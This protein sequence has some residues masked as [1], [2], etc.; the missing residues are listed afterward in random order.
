MPAYSSLSGSE[1]EGSCTSQPRIAPS[2]P[3]AETASAFPFTDAALTCSDSCSWKRN[4]LDSGTTT[5]TAC[6]RRVPGSSSTS[7]SSEGVAAG[8]AACARPAP[9]ATAIAARKRAIVKA[10]AGT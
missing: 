2:L 3:A 5:A 8:A 9:S 6:S 10:S 7:R 1:P 4:S